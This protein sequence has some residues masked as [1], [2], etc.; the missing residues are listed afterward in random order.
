MQKQHT[1]FGWNPCRWPPPGVPFLPT[2]AGRCCHLWAVSNSHPGPLNSHKFTDSSGIIMNNH[3]KKK[4]YQQY[5]KGNMNNII[6][7]MLTCYKCR[8]SKCNNTINY[9][10]HIQYVKWRSNMQQPLSLTFPKLALFGTELTSAPGPKTVIRK[11][12][13]ILNHP[14]MVT[15]GDTVGP[16]SNHPFKWCTIP[17]HSPELDDECCRKNGNHF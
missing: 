14:W 1:T 9:N 8:W 10:I 7:L 4:V 16:Y 6:A 3:Y 13:T 5:E 2:D 15:K 17:I 11:W 12:W